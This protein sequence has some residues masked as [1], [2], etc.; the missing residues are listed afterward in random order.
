MRINPLVIIQMCVGERGGLI[1]IVTSLHFELLRNR[2]LV[3]AKGIILSSPPPHP[4]QD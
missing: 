2:G 4:P 1:H 3:S